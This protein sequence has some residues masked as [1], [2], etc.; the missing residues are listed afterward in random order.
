MMLLAVFMFS[1]MD[2]VLKMLVVDYG[3]LQVTF[4][5][6]YISLTIFLVWILATDP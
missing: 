6:C 1:T 2:V 4:Y 5:R 3:S